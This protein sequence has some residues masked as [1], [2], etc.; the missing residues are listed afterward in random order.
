MSLVEAAVGLTF[1]CSSI[2]ALLS[3]VDSKLSMVVSTAVLVFSFLLEDFFG[4]PGS[5]SCFA[6][7]HPFFL[8]FRSPARPNPSC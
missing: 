1:V 8:P 2:A 5:L 6:F 4:A 7:H 3:Q